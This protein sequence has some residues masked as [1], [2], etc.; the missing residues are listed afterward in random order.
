[1]NIESMVNALTA[2]LARPYSTSKDF[3]TEIDSD[4][5]VEAASGG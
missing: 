4:A 1:M 2:N 5:N 3:S